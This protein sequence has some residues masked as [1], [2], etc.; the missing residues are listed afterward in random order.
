MPF[1]ATTNLPTTVT[2]K[3]TQGKAMGGGA[4]PQTQRRVVAITYTH[5][6]A[7]MQTEAGELQ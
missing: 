7:H 4:G 6:H 2:G 5:T 1:P 3:D